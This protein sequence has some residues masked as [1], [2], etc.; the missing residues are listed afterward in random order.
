MGASLW[1]GGN[2]TTVADDSW[3]DVLGRFL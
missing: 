1:T 2:E 3:R